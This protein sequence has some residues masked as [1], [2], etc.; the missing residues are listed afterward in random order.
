MGYFGIFIVVVLGG[1]GKS[2]NNGGGGGGGVPIIETLI[3]KP[4]SNLFNHT[5]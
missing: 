5:I 1:G 2:G 3:P 4:K